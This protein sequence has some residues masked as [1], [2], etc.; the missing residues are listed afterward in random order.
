MTAPGP[1]G[2]LHLSVGPPQARAPVSPDILSAA[3][4]PSLADGM[5]KHLATTG[6][7]VDDGIV[8][9]YTDQLKK[10][11]KLETAGRLPGDG[12]DA[13][14]A[15]RKQLE[16]FRKAGLTDLV[17]PAESPP[18]GQGG[19]LAGTL[20]ALGAAGGL[21][22]SG[23]TATA[24]RLSESANVAAARLALEA[25]RGA[26]GRAGEFFYG[27]ANGFLTILKGK[28]DF[29]KGK[30]GTPQE[31]QSVGIDVASLADSTHTQASYE[32]Q[33]VNRDRVT[34]G[35]DVPGYLDEMVVEAAGELGGL[36]QQRTDLTASRERNEGAIG[37]RT[38]RQEVVGETEVVDVT[39]TDAEKDGWVVA[40]NARI[41]AENAKI[42][43]ISRKPK[44][45]L[46][47]ID[48][49][50]T[51]RKVTR[52]KTVKV[53]EYTF[54]PE[55]A[56]PVAEARASLAEAMQAESDA[57]SKLNRYCELEGLTEH[58]RSGYAAWIDVMQEAGLSCSNTS[59]ELADKLTTINSNTMLRGRILGLAKKINLTEADKK[60]FGISTIETVEELF[61]Y[62]EARKSDPR[63]QGY[64][65]VTMALS[66]ADQAVEKATS[67]YQAR[68][69][70]A[71]RW[72]V[73]SRGR[74]TGAGYQ[75]LADAE[76]QTTNILATLGDTAIV[77]LYLRKRY[78]PEGFEGNQG[79][80]DYETVTA[81]QAAIAAGNT[82]IGELQNEITEYFDKLKAEKAPSVRVSMQHEIDVKQGQVEILQ[83]EITASLESIRQ[84]MDPS[85]RLVKAEG[86][87]RGLGNS[88][89]DKALRAVGLEPGNDYNRRQQLDR[90]G[91]AFTQALR[92]L[93][94]GTVPS[95]L[96]LFGKVIA[97]LRGEP[98]PKIVEAPPAS[99]E[100]PPSPAAPGAGAAVEAG[101]ATEEAGEQIPPTEA[102]RR[103]AAE[104]L[105]QEEGVRGRLTPE[106]IINMDRATYAVQREL[107]EERSVIEG[108]ES[109]KKEEYGRKLLATV[110][111]LKEKTSAERLELYRTAVPP[112]ETW[113]QV[114]YESMLK[115]G[116][117][118]KDIAKYAK[119]LI[120]KRNIMQYLPGIATLLPILLQLFEDKSV[121]ASAQGGQEQ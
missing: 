30:K 79:G 6:R 77:D 107:S 120:G 49:A 86:V 119:D 92:E 106:E 76:R 63:L 12:K 121:A 83:E 2:A 74:P 45:P 64:E 29:V 99:Q 36:E 39:L 96:E 62:F 90:V 105:A 104:A 5:R 88:E 40:E 22:T 18:A 32:A 59:V 17:E 42:G 46:V 34:G 1:E 37:T 9:K 66:D 54:D 78:L 97:I 15:A 51:A 85:A 87:I 114:I 65:Q 71:G 21:D 73:D 117:S 60:S 55:H 100:P 28:V 94:K 52:P 67:I 69:T 109:T 44:Q 24:A 33:R 31:A 8:L 27:R 91:Q 103:S 113:E 112:I 111:F 53:K 110:N 14:Q 3:P 58:N 101:V 13:V 48:K 20:A 116:Y 68:Q 19:D 98:A 56:A 115:F 26:R 4:K 35:K 16:E 38:V 10:L 72:S 95:E 81:R 80:D 57:A 84:I 102:E 11:L 25:S 118:E 82:K 61:K 93:P 41:T 47:T 50:P 43:R 89:V 75:E 23:L 7:Q 108:M 70:E